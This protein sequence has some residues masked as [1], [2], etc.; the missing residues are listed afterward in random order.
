MPHNYKVNSTSKVTAQVEDKVISVTGTTRKVLRA[1]I[2]QNPNNPTASVRAAV[3]HQRKK[4]SDEWEDIADQ[5]LSSLKAGEAKKMGF[6]SAETKNL[7]DE[8]TRIYS[9]YEAKGVQRGQQKY[10]VGKENEIIFTDPERAKYIKQLLA[11]GHSKEI[12]EEL[13]Q[14]NPNLADQ[15]ALHRLA[16]SRQNAVNEF[17]QNIN[18]EQSE[19]YWQKFF[20]NNEW[21]F[22][23]GLNYRFLKDLQDQ[24]SL[25]GASVSGKGNQKGDFLKATAGETSFTVLVEIKTPSTDLVAKT[26][27]RNGAFAVGGEVSG[28]VA[29]LQMNCRQWEVESSRL[30]ANRDL[31]AKGIHTL[32]PKGILVIGSL[33]QLNSREKRNSF[34]AYRRNLLNPE[35]IAFDELLERAKFIASH[36]KT[37]S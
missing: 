6:D 32:Q 24:P 11:R 3:I 17:V 27:Y 9:I 18:R 10:V 15:L 8:L 37:E 35:I 34:E 4:P 25:G 14:Q 31:E 12:W 20:K 22:G 36:H 19:P 7:F 13:I 29:Q 5:P 1:E 28:G 2:I 33:G 26:A 23:L 30:D 21:I 16:Q